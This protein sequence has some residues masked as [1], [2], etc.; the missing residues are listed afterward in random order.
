MQRVEGR[1]RCEAHSDG[2]KRCGDWEVADGP[3]MDERRPYFLTAWDSSL[4]KQVS[5]ANAEGWLSD[6]DSV[7]L[8]VVV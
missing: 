1:R 5:G 4:D 8:V 6:L 3:A 7:I 2:E